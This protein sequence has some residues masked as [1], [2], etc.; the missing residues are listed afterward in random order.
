[1]KKILFIGAH[2]DDIELGCGGTLSRFISEKYDVKVI[3]FS[4][5]K[6]LW[7]E[8]A[9]EAIN[10]MEVFDKNNFTFEINDLMSC[11]TVFQ[12]NRQLIY[13]ILEINRNNF[14]PDMVFVHSTFD[15]NQ[16][17]QVVSAETI[18]VFKKASSIYGYEFPNNNMKFDYDLFIKLE[19]KH[20]LKKIEA[21]KCYKSQQ[22][23]ILNAHNYFDPEYIKALAIV[24]G[25]Q[26]LTKYAECFEVIRG[27]F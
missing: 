10:S 7:P 6:N 1:M 12:D 23:N 2:A 26:V 15:T 4:V 21:L 8:Q 17:H 3:V 16:D 18:R 14:N 11:G 9:V 22:S 24:R 25:Q 27:I 13:T 20:I 19:E 5:N